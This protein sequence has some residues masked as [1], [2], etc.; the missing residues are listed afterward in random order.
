MLFMNV[1]QI[2]HLIGPERT[3]EQIT[4][5]N[6]AAAEFFSKRWQRLVESVSSVKT[7]SPEKGSVRNWIIASLGSATL[8]VALAPRFLDNLPAEIEP[9]D[10]PFITYTVKPGDNLSDIAEPYTPE[11]ESTAD[12]VKDIAFDNGLEDEDKIFP[13]QVLE[14]RLE[15]WDNE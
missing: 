11:G 13:G 2:N 8:I 10:G 4:S 14:I 5:D 9:H 7:K 1:S 12:L 6:K 3:A 15:H